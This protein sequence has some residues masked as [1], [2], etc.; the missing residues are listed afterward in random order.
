[1]EG[2]TQSESGFQ[3]SAGGRSVGFLAGDRIRLKGRNDAFTGNDSR[4]G[5]R[6]AA[7]QHSRSRQPLL[8]ALQAGK[9]QSGKGEVLQAEA[10][11]C[12]G[13]GSGLL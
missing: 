10:V 11:L 2:F 12:S 13:S 4:S 6:H 5:S 8:Q 3:D 7:G 1:L 9:V